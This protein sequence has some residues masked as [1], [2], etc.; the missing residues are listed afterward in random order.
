MQNLLW[1]VGVMSV[2]V[3]S[4]N[5]QVLRS[6]PL[7]TNDLIFEQWS[8]RL[9]ASVPSTAAPGVANSIVPINPLTAQAESP[10]AVGVGPNKLAVSDNGQYLYS[11]LDG[12]SPGVQRVDLTS[13]VPDLF[14]TLGSDPIS[15]TYYAGDL[16]VVPGAA[17]SL[18]VSRR[19]FGH[20]PRYEGVVAYDHGV[21]RPVITTEH[22]GSNVIEFGA[23]AGT[24]YGYDHESTEFGSRTMRVDPSG[25]E[26]TSLTTR[27]F[28]G[29]NLDFVFD[30]QWAIAT[31]GQAVDPGSETAVGSYWPFGPTTASVVSDPAN[32][33]VFFLKGGTISVY[34]RDD[35]TLRS[36]ILIPGAS[37]QTAS[38]MRWGAD[39][40]AFRDRTNNLVW[41]YNGP[42]IPAPSTGCIVALYFMMFARRTAR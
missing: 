21:P 5:A 14:F 35:F 9:Y 19:N 29:F 25:V 31:S 39:G 6:V 1:S 18:I 2:G 22:L 37:S 7:A 27:L 34:D 42:E 26:I 11:G 41:L 24:L 12:T 40:L 30:G 17:H 3:L 36:T 4:A 32:D 20:S 16:E 38:L 28:V 23:Q 8:S 33:A 10:I 13:R 15:G